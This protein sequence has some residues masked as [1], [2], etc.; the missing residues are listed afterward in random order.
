MDRPCGSGRA[1]RWIAVDADGGW[2]ACWRS[3]SPRERLLPS[4]STPVPRFPPAK[5]SSPVMRPATGTSRKTSQKAAS[6]PTTPRR[7]ASCACR[8]SQRFSRR[9]FV[10][11]GK[12][13]LAARLLLSTI[14]VIGCWL[15]FEL[16]RRLFDDRVAFVAAAITAVLPTFVAFS[17]LLL[18][19]T[20]F[21]V[22]LVASLI[23]AASLLQGLADPKTPSSRLLC[24]AGVCGDTDQPGLLHASQLVVVGATSSRFAES[25]SVALGRSPGWSHWCSEPRRS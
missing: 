21:A 25:S 17:P 3:L 7:G 12:N 5:I 14:A 2:A 13:P 10:T 15:V 24:H 18:S 4:P 20:A 1:E 11:F 22:T 9:L 19:E 23:P 8:A 16:G 6:T